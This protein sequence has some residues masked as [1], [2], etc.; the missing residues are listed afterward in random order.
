MKKPKVALF[1]PTYNQENYIIESL[2]SAYA[3]KYR[4]LIIY[5]SDD[6]STDNTFALIENFQKK[7]N[8]RHE[9]ILKRREKNL[10]LAM[11]IMVT[12]K[13]ISD[14]VDFVVCQAGDDIS[15]PE[16][17]EKLTELWINLGSSKY[18]YIHTPVEI[19][20]TNG[21][22]KGI[23]LPP[24]NQRPIDEEHIS[25]NP[26]SHGLVIGASTAFAPSLVT[27]IP[28]QF[29]NLYEDQVLTFRAMIHKTLIY[30]GETLVK[31][32]FGRGVSTSNEDRSS[33]ESRI[34]ITT[35]DTLKQRKVD[36]DFF[37]RKKISEKIGIE[38]K[39]WEKLAKIKNLI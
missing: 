24:I 21:N 26:T 4:N 10:G 20:D 18:A 33:Y 36:A 16:R 3:Q 25:T 13:E 12:I 9:I 17:V 23:W 30:W 31:Y 37:K 34:I 35:I 11:N 29:P 28:F 15:E 5:I 19:I 8:T 22:S 2:K 38:I 6:S 14:L 39:K 32:R 7:T 27:Q 1:I